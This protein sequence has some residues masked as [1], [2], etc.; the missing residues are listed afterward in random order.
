MPSQV[1][2]VTKTNLRQTTDITM[3]RKTLWRLEDTN[4]STEADVGFNQARETDYAIQALALHT[5]KPVCDYIVKPC[6]LVS[7]AIFHL[8]LESM[9]FLQK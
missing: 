8:Q 3:R 7:R 4:D 1:A 5:P 6:Y 9:Y 2:L